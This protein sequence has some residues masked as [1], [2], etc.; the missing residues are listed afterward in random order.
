MREEKKGERQACV[1]VDTYHPVEREFHHELTVED[2][3]LTNNT[4]VSDTKN[5]E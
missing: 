2:H 4:D 5:E 3:H 1:C